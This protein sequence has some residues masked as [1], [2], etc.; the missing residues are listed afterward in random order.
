MKKIIIIVLSIILI[1]MIGYYF[2]DQYHFIGGGDSESKPSE[3]PSGVS[4]TVYVGEVHRFNNDS[5]L[6]SSNDKVAIVGDK[7][8]LFV[9]EG[10]VIITYNGTEKKEYKVIEKENEVKVN[11]ITIENNLIEI[12]VGES[13]DLKV[14]FEPDNATYKNV[15]WQSNKPNVVSVDNGKVKGLQ[16]GEAVVSLK[17]ARGKT[18][19]AL[20]KVLDNTINVSNVTLDKQNVALTIGEESNIKATISPSNATEKTITW[21]SSDNSVVSVD[22]N[23]HIKALKNGTAVIKATSGNGV[24]AICNVT[25]GIPVEKLTLSKTSTTLKVG[26]SEKLYVAFSPTDATNRKVTW[27]SSDASVVAVEKGVIT[28]KG[29]GTAIIGVT[30]TNGKTASCTVTVTN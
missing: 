28:A 20:V 6:S 16:V 24:S 17:G 30:S 4:N 22:N 3:K 10:N 14:T 26:A 21:S 5:N 19:Q 13:A 7:M 8:V 2:N 29:V 11:R 27:S 18:A 1:V 12:H 25:V 9:G 15:V 23:G